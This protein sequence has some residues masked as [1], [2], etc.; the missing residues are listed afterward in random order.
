M[1]ST[2]SP[3]LAGS[4]SASSAP[5]CEP[6]PSV[7]S[8]PTAAAS[9][10]SIGQLS[11]FSEI[12]ESL[13]QS[14]LWPTP[15]G[16]CVPNKRWAGPSGNELGRAVNQSMSSAAGFPARTSPRQERARALAALARDYGASSPE[17]L[18][19]FDPATSSWRTSQLC[20]DGDLSVFSE[21]WPRSGTMRNGTAYR[22]PPL[23]PLTDAT[24]SGLL[25]TPTETGNQL[26]PS[27]MK[28]PGCAAW[29]PTPR[30]SEWKGTGP[31]GSKSHAYRLERS[32]LDATVQEVAQTSGALNP[33]WVE[34]LMGFP[35]GWTDCGP[36][37]M[38][39]S[40]RSRKS[41][42]GRS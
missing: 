4:A 34:W 30:A 8:I 32:Y 31:L 2:S 12:S 23:A 35:L 21:T 42:G 38:P 25:A 14:T 33:T 7:R 17:L 29:W 36:S 19:R 41:S 20:L 15:H 40:P 6:S 39:S 5:E 26:S 10:P 37:G 16:M 22:L 28:W 13:P 3:E 1:C 11:L 27:M 24:G 9:S 18:A